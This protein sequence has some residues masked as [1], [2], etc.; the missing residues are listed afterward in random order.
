MSWVVFALWLTTIV[1]TWNVAPYIPDK[2]AKQ[3]VPFL[4]G[5]GIASLLWS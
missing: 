3:L 4:Y 2:L 5:F 1:V